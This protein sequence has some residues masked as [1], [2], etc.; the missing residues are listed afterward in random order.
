MSKALIEIVKIVGDLDI[1][2]YDDSFLRQSA[3]KR[4]AVTGTSTLSEYV[5]FV[6]ETPAEAPKLVRSLNITHTEFFRNSLSFAHLEQWILPSLLAG[7]A[8]GSEL[9]IWSAGCSTGQEAYSIAMLVENMQTKKSK[10]LRYRIIATDIS[11]SALLQG[12]RGKYS[13]KDIQRIRVK[14]LK[15]FF[16][17]TGDTYTVCDSVK[18][19]VSFSSYDL[20]DSFSSYPQ[21][22]IFGDFDLVVCSNVLFY[23]KPNCQMDIV[24][25]L[26]NS[27]DKGGYLIT[28]E[29]ERHTME[30]FS[31]LYQVA[32]PSPIYKLRSGMK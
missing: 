3:E 26:I 11:E 6:S 18:S 8:E 5:Q 23:Y 28:G 29:T 13:E 31:E 21:E 16:I 27:L 14:D 2:N 17:K 1:S 22:S 19:H 24:K 7:E 20:L 32:P 15:E 12:S 4:F 10:K 25:K 9:R 30:K